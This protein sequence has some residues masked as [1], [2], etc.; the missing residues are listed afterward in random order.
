MDHL[1]PWAHADL[2]VCFLLEI[3]AQSA[4]TSIAFAQSTL[5]LPMLPCIGPLKVEILIDYIMI[6]F[7]RG[8]EL[9]STF[10]S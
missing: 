9:A 2:G 4:P 10:V 8:R 7:I 3:Y 6:G 1:V 5:F